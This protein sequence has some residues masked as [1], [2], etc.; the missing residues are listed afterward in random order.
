M[1][2]LWSWAVFGVKKK[3]I[4]FIAF[5]EISES[6]L[7]MFYTMFFS[8]NSYENIAWQY[9]KGFPISGTTVYWSE[10]NFFVIIWSPELTDCTIQNLADW[11]LS[12]MK[13]LII[14]AQAHEFYCLS[15]MYESVKDIPEFEKVLDSPE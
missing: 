12:L 6:V 11:V 7:E 9:T 15:H 13:K 2:G 4:C 10:F 3:T 5:N 14:V 1:D 8:L